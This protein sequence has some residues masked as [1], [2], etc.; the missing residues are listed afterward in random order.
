MKR[1]LTIAI[2]GIFFAFTAPANAWF[3]FLPLGAIAD[4]LEKDPDKATFSAKDRHYSKC[5]GYHLNQANV[6]S[7]P[8]EQADFHRTIAERAEDASQDK[9]QVKQIGEVYS[10][11]WSKAAGVDIQTNRNFGADLAK[12]CKEVG[13]P[14]SFNEYAGWQAREQDAKQRTAEE[15][16]LTQQEAIMPPIQQTTSENAQGTQTD[17]SPSAQVDFGLEATKASRI[18]GCTPQELKVVGVKDKNILYD[19]TCLGGISLHLACDATGLCLKNK[20]VRPPI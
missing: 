11:R 20:D 13:L 7:K 4:A 2:A 5:S 17:K 19:V 15:V 18:L 16:K 14:V 3:I 8:A 1:F 12:S 9:S 10:R 6:T